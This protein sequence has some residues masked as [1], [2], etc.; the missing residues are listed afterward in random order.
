[1]TTGQTTSN[2]AVTGSF[3]IPLMKKA[4]YKPEVAGAIEAAA[5]GGGQI[6]PPIMGAGAFVMADLLGV[7]YTDVLKMAILPAIFYYVSLLIFVHLQALKS[8]IVPPEEKMDLQRVVATAPL[9]VI[10]IV[11]IL[12]ILFLGYPPGIGAFW[13]IVAL[14][15]L[16]Y[17][18]KDTRPGLRQLFEGCY[19]GAKIGAT[20]AAAVASI[21]PAI[22]LM[23]KTG[24]GMTIGYSVERWSFGSPFIGL[25]ILMLATIVLGMELPTVAAYLIAAVIAVPPLVAMGLNVYGAHM[26]AYYFSSFSALT[27]PIGMA[28]VVASR[29]AN[30]KYLRTAY[31]AIVAAGAGYL[32]PYLFVYD[33]QLLLRNIHPL[34]FVFLLSLVV[35]GLIAIQ[36][37]FVGFFINRLGPIGILL[38]LISGIGIF[39][40]I[41]IHS[42]VPI[43]VISILILIAV[44]GFEMLKKRKGDKA[45]REMVSV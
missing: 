25:I 2:I 31:H 1:M 7:P 26:F 41:I 35:I 12:V 37:G 21:G 22:A 15:V 8:N 29:L 43:L 4:G 33:E 24:L 20:L 38:S 28:A 39:S 17:L 34:N 42:N 9:F 44:M 14:V 30:A 13:G 5:S 16:A 40:F 45:A 32:L 18:R 23:T 6:T 27:P 19:Q 10:P 11:T 36:M 3:T